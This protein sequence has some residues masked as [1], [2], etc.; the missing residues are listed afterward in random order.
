MPELQRQIDAVREA[1]SA[2]V[3]KPFALKP[4]FPYGSPHPSHSA[5]PP[6]YRAAQRAGS[7]EQA[8][9]SS[10]GQTVSY[11]SHP[12]SPPISNGPLDSK[13]DSP[14]AQSLVMMPQAVGPG[15]SQNMALPEQPAWNP[16]KI[17]EYVSTSEVDVSLDSLS[18]SFHLPLRALRHTL[19]I[20]PS[21]V[22]TVAM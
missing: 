18:L 1:F 6:G 14:S 10:G 11:L 12:I 13:S 19:L 4:S 21:H 20:H 22:L 17:F 15:I 3:R 7:M 8:L 16:A 9:D 5:S 2:D